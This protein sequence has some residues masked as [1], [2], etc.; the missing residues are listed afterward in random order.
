MENPPHLEIKNILKG[1]CTANILK[2]H[3]SCV[4][5][6]VRARAFVCVCVCVC[7]WGGGLNTVIAQPDTWAQNYENLPNQHGHLHS[8]AVYEFLNIF[9]VFCLA[10]MAFSYCR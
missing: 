1:H 8:H 9:F 3:A 7:V 10:V 5:V 4:C 6:C 2:K